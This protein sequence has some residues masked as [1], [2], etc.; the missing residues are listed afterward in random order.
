[1][2]KSFNIVLLV[3][4]LFDVV[5]AIDH[6][7]CTENVDAAAIVDA[8]RLLEDSIPPGYRLTEFYPT[9]QTGRNPHR[10]I[11]S[12]ERL[13][14]IYRQDCDYLTDVRRAFRRD[15]PAGC[16][17][18]QVVVS[19][20]PNR[21]FIQVQFLVNCLCTK[22]P[23]RRRDASSGYRNCTNSFNPIYKREQCTC[24]GLN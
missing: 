20:S 9:T 19:Q 8:E 4:L 24:T 6:M 11:C 18:S 10:W 15:C 2:S 7:P 5:I 13:D 23:R 12:Y 16:E 14:G 22:I 17:I 21:Q 3:L 1:M